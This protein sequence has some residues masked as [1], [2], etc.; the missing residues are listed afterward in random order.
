[1]CCRHPDKNP[2]NP[3]E[4]NT[5][6]QKL[7]AAYQKLTQESDDS[8]D[9]YF[10]SEDMEDAFAFFMNMYGPPLSSFCQTFIMFVYGTSQ[11]CL[12]CQYICD[13]FKYPTFA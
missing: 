7:Y 11:H 2:D 8:D 4:A 6:F 13:N 1:M 5:K 9:D 12:Y 10:M 3:D